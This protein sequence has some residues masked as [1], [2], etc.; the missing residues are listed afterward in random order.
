M[1]ELAA[2]LCSCSSQ[3]SPAQTAHSRKSV[4]KKYFKLNWKDW[5]LFEKCRFPRLHEM[6]RRR[7]RRS[8]RGYNFTEHIAF[9][10]HIATMSKTMFQEEIPIAD[11]R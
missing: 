9:P 4:E 2:V 3:H 8:L 6:R 1:Y 10:F 7:E 11:D 5:L